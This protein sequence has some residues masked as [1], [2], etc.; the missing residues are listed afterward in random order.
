MERYFIVY[1]VTL[2][3][4]LL[5]FDY[6][7]SDDEGRQNRSQDEEVV[8]SVHLKLNLFIKNKFCYSEYN[9]KGGWL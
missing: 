8:Q 2:L 3:Q 9:Y 5:E 4:N 1:I 6:D 7:E